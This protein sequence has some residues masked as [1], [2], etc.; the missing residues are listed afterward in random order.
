MTP[1]EASILIHCYGREDPV[2]N[3]TRNSQTLALDTFV[4]NGVLTPVRDAGCYALTA[5]G[6]FWVKGM[7]AIPMPTET[8][9][10]E[11]IRHDLSIGV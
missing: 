3:Y 1:L 6:E 2:P 5:K 8:Y 7:L 4:D 10:F 11:G 9:A